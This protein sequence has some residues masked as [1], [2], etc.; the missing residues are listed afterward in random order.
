MEPNNLQ[1]ALPCLNCGHSLNTTDLITDSASEHLSLGKSNDAPDDDKLRIIHEE[2][3]QTKQRLADLVV[4]EAQLTK[5]VSRARQRLTE[6]LITYESILAPIRF[7]PADIILEILLMCFSMRR[8]DLEQ[9][10]ASKGIRLPN[11]GSLDTKEPPWVFGQV[12]R[13]WRSIVTSHCAF[14]TGFEISL[15][16]DTKDYFGYMETLLSLQVQRAGSL[17]PICISLCV[18]LSPN[19][20]SHVYPLL[21]VILSRS[22]QWKKL[23]ISA[24]GEIFPFLASVRGN[25]ASLESL[26]IDIPLSMITS[27]AIVDCFRSVPK[28]N[29]LTLQPS[30]S[31]N[32]IMLPYDQ[33]EVLELR[34][35]P[36]HL[37]T[38]MRQTSFSGRTLRTLILYYD[39]GSSQANIT[40]PF[41]LR[42]LNTLVIYSPRLSELD[43]DV[44]YSINV[45]VLKSLRIAGHHS[46]TP[47]LSFLTRLHSSYQLNL[48]HL[49]LIG[50]AFISS[51]SELI[52]FLSHLNG[53]RLTLES[54]TLY[55]KQ[56]VLLKHIHRVLI[57]N[58][59]W[60]T[61]VRELGFDS[62]T[63]CEPDRPLEYAIEL[64]DQ[65][66]SGHYAS[67]KSV[68][69]GL[70]KLRLLH[71]RVEMPTRLIDL[72]ARGLEVVIEGIHG[73]NVYEEEAVSVPLY[74]EWTGRAFRGS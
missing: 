17:L 62:C 67:V 19:D 58:P 12:C 23:Y 69:D 61:K 49:S 6:Q 14:W 26:S 25:L 43:L 21:S 2:V 66:L 32:K 38:L 22:S 15:G 63:I 34:H 74:E 71:P 29:E 36:W 33:L 30:Q 35:D 51:S 20:L 68:D 55:C 42:S 11:F 1:F 48:K 59:M 9:E 50:L 5:S 53:S 72:E 56:F 70:R 41:E 73:K 8:N 44:L 18:D 57:Q 64:V 52:G 45:P 40:A 13:Y 27:Y 65:R 54:L 46:L 39:E 28:L 37:A 31:L 4:F 3:A 10:N 47:V 60:L 16:Q 7:L 24:A